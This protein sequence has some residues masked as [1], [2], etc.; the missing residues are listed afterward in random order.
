[1]SSPKITRML[2]FFPAA[3][4]HAELKSN[5]TNKANL[6]RKA[7]AFSRAAAVCRLSAGFCKQ[8]RPLPPP[9][10]G[11]LTSDSTVVLYGDM[12]WGKLMKIR[13][14]ALTALLILAPAQAL[15]AEPL[16]SWSEGDAKTSILGF[17]DKV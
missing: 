7:I 10:P 6:G 8:P 5:N 3:A 16:A 1:M 12:P 9:R 4:A 17:V 15:S 14:T 13:A 2:G 11:W